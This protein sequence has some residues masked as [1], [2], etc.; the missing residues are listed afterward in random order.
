VKW[1]DQTERL[2]GKINYLVN[3]KD[4]Q[5]LPKKQAYTIRGIYSDF[6]YH[7]VGEAFYQMQFD[8]TFIR[9]WRTPPLWGV[10][11][12]G[13][14]GHDGASLSLHDVIVRHGGEALTSRKAYTNLNEKQRE[15]LIAFLNSLVLYQTDQLPCDM[16]GDG[17]ISDPFIVQGMNTGIERFNPEW[18]FKVPG[19][20]EGPIKNVLG[21]P[22]ISN[23][24]TNA[25]EAYG[26]YLD[27][28]IDTDE[29]GWPD[30]IDVAPLKPGYKDGEN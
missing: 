26:A 15:Q 29:D 19:K 24:L 30:V 28:L 8:G 5:W 17:K 10:G 20:I 13:P 16:N 23:A 4:G 18:L 7:D 22:I 2:E 12:T 11:T 9:K 27:Y 6:K 14:Y 3:K 25:R 21:E 1:N